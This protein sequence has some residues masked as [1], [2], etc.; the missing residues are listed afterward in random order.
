MAFQAPVSRRD[1][2]SPTTKNV[3][4]MAA[5]HAHQDGDAGARRRGQAPQ[6]AAR[7]ASGWLVHW[8]RWRAP[9][10][11]A[12]WRCASGSASSSLVSRSC[13][14]P[15]SS[16]ASSSSPSSTASATARGVSRGRP[17]GAPPRQPPARSSRSS[18]A[19]GRSRARQGRGRCAGADGGLQREASQFRQALAARRDGGHHR[20]RQGSSELRD[21]DLE[22]AALGLVHEVQRHHHAVAEVRSCST[23]YRLRARLVA[24]TTTTTTSGC[25]VEQRRRAHR[26]VARV[27]L[28]GV[29]A[30]Q[31]DHLDRVPA[32]R[33]AHV[34]PPR[35]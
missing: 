21:V 30:G 31:V 3:A 28:K 9:R 6:A 23:R 17:R 20:R 25:R 32:P 24:S 14:L 12:P 4:N 2:R 19:A 11:G 18:T 8:R 33:V 35:W 16:A 34:A 22:L 26:L 5:M 13:G 1:S 7:A 29:G 10:R 15:G 27:R